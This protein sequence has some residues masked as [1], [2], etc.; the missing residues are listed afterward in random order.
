M[1]NINI[2]WIV[3]ELERL[4]EQNSEFGGRHVGTGGLTVG[5]LEHVH[6]FLKKEKNNTK[7]GNVLFNDALNTYLF[8]VIWHRTYGK[9]P[10]SL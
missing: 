10:F 6:E 5:R 3:D 8:T 7:E 1:K 9:G 4:V 2:P